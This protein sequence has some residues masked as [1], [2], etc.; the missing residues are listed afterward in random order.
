MG[1]TLGY[2]SDYGSEPPLWWALRFC[3]DG[4][5]IIAIEDRGEG[6]WIAVDGWWLSDAQTCVDVEGR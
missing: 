6:H 2:V 4:P 1:L 3:P 5:L